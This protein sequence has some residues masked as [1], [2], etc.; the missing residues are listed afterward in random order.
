MISKRRV[1]KLEQQLA[2]DDQPSIYFIE[3]LAG[4]TEEE[5]CE[6]L[7]YNVTGKDMIIVMSMSE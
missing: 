6:R 4:E 2:P 3:T 7:H 5:A 1:E